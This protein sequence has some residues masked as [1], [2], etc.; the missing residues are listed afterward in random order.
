VQLSRRARGLPFWFSLSVHGTQQYADAIEHTLEVARAGAELIRER[1]HVRLLVEPE[2][3]VLVFER[4]G[5][6]G[7]DY[8]RWSSRILDEQL[9][10]VT[11]T[12]HR[13]RI[14]TRFAVVNPLTTPDDLATLLDSMH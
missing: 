5:W 10:F 14:C 9:G 6:D 1:D 4:I 3:S 13:G 2:L 11:P 12:T 7:D 8:A